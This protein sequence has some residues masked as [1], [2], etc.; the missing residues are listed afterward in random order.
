MGLV[1]YLRSHRALEGKQCLAGDPVTYILRGTRICHV[2]TRS[3][4][5]YH[6]CLMFNTLSV[7][8]AGAKLTPFLLDIDIGC[9]HPKMA[10]TPLR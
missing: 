6:R 1:H 4:E 9:R 7:H 8:L 3:S 5:Y 10:Y 2:R